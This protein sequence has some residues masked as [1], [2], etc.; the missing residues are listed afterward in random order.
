[1]ADNLELSQK[2]L[3]VLGCLIEK[4][5]STPTYY[6]LSINTL[7][8]ACN[9]RSNRDPI[10][11]YGDSDIEAAL[12]ALMHEGFASRIRVTGSRVEKYSHQIYDRLDISPREAA[13]LAELML[14]GPQTPGELNTRASRMTSFEGLEEVDITLGSLIEA[15]FV[16][17]LERMPGQ[18]ERR[19][20]HQLG[21]AETAHVQEHTESGYTEIAHIQDD[22]LPASDIAT[23][24]LDG[25]VQALEA[26]VARLRAEVDFMRSG[27]GN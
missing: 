14:R 4:Q 20:A 7:L 16:I 25:R 21:Q 9:Q 17:R 5:L 13:V 6:P 8:N 19:Y 3:R 22:I 24:G 23:G 11:V 2:Q 26:E 12:S 18:K 15:G 27:G 10:T 1:M